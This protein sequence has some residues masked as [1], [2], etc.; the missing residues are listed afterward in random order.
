[1]TLIKLKL[2]DEKPAE[3]AELSDLGLKHFPSQ[4]EFLQGQAAAYAQLGDAARM[5]QALKELARISPD[6]ASP[7]HPLAELAL[8]RKRYTDAVREAKSALHG[9]VLDAQIHRA[10][11]EACLGT[12]E[13]TKALPELEAASELKPKA[14]EI[15]LALA[16]G[17]AAVGRK[18]DAKM[19]PQA[20][21][22]RDAKNAEVRAELETLK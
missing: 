14:D 20:I 6:Y 12:K 5:T 15:E 18:A 16:N 13:P 17:L 19:H 4:P 8:K 11:G 2:L 1:M 10:L 22:E 9:D 7:R 21:L 3:A